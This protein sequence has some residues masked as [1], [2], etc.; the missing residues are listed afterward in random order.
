MKYD[1]TSLG[2]DNA[3]DCE[4][5]ST[6]ETDSTSLTSSTEKTIIATSANQNQLTMRMMMQLIQIMM[7]TK[8]IM[9]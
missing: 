2:E 6:C 8:I 7:K 5:D 9:I 1:N 4:S 3:H